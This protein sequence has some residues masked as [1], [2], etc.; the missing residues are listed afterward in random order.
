MHTDARKFAG[1][2]EDV[3]ISHQNPGYSACPEQRRLSLSGLVE[4]Y[5]A[6][7]MHHLTSVSWSGMVEKTKSRQDLRRRKHMR[8]APRS[9]H[10]LL[11]WPNEFKRKQY[12]IKVLNWWAWR[13]GHELWIRQALSNTHVHVL[14]RTTL[15][16]F[17][18]TLYYYQRSYC[19]HYSTLSSSHCTMT[20]IGVGCG[21]DDKTTRE[22]RIMLPM[23]SSSC[24]EQKKWWC[25]S[26]FVSQFRIHG[27]FCS[28]Q[29]FVRKVVQSSQQEGVRGRDWGGRGEGTVIKDRIPGETM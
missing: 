21:D 26:S 17:C 18:A 6:W 22:K 14:L 2:E 4:S 13:I 15:Y 8:C 5:A 24:S 9:S 1:A 3:D 19:H 28:P 7:R 23:S 29:V 27:I 12:R 11:P 16:Y 10:C 25:W 20:K